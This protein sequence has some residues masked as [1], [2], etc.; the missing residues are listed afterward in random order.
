MIL[1]RIQDTFEML[2]GYTRLL[3]FA[4]CIRL[5]GYRVRL[6]WSRFYMREIGWYPSLQIELS[7]KSG[8]YVAVYDECMF[9]LFTVK[10]MLKDA[11]GENSN[12]AETTKA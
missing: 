11:L 12:A 6:H 1:W 10:H 5:Q 3:F 4:V 9:R 8:G 2:V 7:T